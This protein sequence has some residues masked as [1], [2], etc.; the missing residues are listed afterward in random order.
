MGYATV[1]V[2]P[3]TGKK[4]SQLYKLFRARSLVKKHTL[5][6]MVL[7]TIYS[8]TVSASAVIP[9]KS[10]HR[11]NVSWNAPINSMATKIL[12]IQ[13]AELINQLHVGAT[14]GEIMT[15]NIQT[16][17]E[18]RQLATAIYPPCL[19]FGPSAKR[20]KNSHTTSM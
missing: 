17:H 18:L 5:A 2:T 10:I 6:C 4:T 7:M 12:Q 14:L 9:P 19:F 15:T 3:H 8:N 1:F 11:C 13:Q 16:A 20:K